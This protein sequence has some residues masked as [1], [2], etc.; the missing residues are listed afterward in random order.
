MLLQY[1]AVPSYLLMETFVITN[2]TRGLVP[3]AF[4]L[5]V[6]S[7]PPDEAA[8][9]QKLQFRAEEAPNYFKCMLERYCSNDDRVGCTNVDSHIPSARAAA[10]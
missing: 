5:E 6:A 3:H 9:L 7:Y 4:A 10:C 8:T 1:T 2:V